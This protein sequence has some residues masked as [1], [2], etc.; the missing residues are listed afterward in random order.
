MFFSLNCVFF[1]VDFL[2]C[3]F[4]L[5]R[6]LRSVGWLPFLLLLSVWQKV[7]E[8]LVYYFVMRLPRLFS[9]PFSPFWRATCYSKCYLSS[10]IVLMRAL[11]CI[12]FYSGVPS[13]LSCNVILILFTAAFRFYSLFNAIRPT[14]RPTKKIPLT[15]FPSRRFSSHS[16]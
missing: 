5:C 8:S 7:T 3:N 16:L 12:G 6:L 15:T 13:F 9:L 4:F 14:D 1:F 10:Y 11:L 2:C